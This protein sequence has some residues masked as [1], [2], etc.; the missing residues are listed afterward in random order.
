MEDHLSSDFELCALDLQCSIRTV[1][2][3]LAHYL[4]KCGSRIGAR[5]V[6]PRQWCQT[7]ALVH[8]RAIYDDEDPPCHLLLAT[9]NLTQ[10]VGRIQQAAP[11]TRED[12]GYWDQWNECYRT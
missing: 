4:N 3:F 5:T 6:H 8:Y 10:E 1:K 11:A 2:K 9:R 7:L 12:D